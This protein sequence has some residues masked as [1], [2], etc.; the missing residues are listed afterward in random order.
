MIIW[1]QMFSAKFK[2]GA[3]QRIGPGKI[4]PGSLDHGGI[5]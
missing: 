5:F 2:E 3:I 4:V 1:T